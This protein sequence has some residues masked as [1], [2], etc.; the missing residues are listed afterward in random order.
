MA[1]F[2]DLYIDEV[3][4][5]TNGG[6]AYTGMTNMLAGTLGLNDLISK[7]S[8]YKFVIQI[9]NGRETAI[10]FATTNAR[11]NVCTNYLD[12]GDEVAYNID[13]NYDLNTGSLAKHD[14]VYVGWD[15]G[16]S[17]ITVHHEESSL[18]MP[19]QKHLGNLIA[20]ARVRLQLDDGSGTLKY[21]DMAG[22]NKKDDGGEFFTGSVVDDVLSETNNQDGSLR[23]KRD[24]QINIPLKTYNDAD[25]RATTGNH[26]TASAAGDPHIKTIH[27]ECYE[28]D[29]LGAFR[30]FEYSKN[31][32]YMII[33]GQSETGPG[34]WNKK[35]YIRKL[36]IQNNISNILLD[37]GFR[38]SPVK[39]LENNGI[40]YKEKTL[41]FNKDAKRYYFNNT[42]FTLDLDEPETEN[43]PGLIRNQLDITLN[44]NNN[45]DNDELAFI[46]LQNVNEFNLQPCRLEI[47]VSKKFINTAKG[48]LIDRKYAPIS[49]LDK[50][51]DITPLE[52]PTLE[53]LKNIPKL[54]IEPKL[55]NIEWK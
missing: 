26:L 42:L 44:I 25:W 1:T 28:F 21:I 37:L 17:G 6:S 20:A 53:D 35:Q 3:Y 48:C 33:N 40:T 10:N 31:G 45:V 46:S 8:G 38:G 18:L 4:I 51:T 50:I 12:D 5:D 47:N 13:K 16:I 32:N 19:N 29:Y 34:R 30:M 14:S 2:T 39:V 43:L 55:R 11:V 49:K 52:E 41:S 23:R 27:G 54:E 22:N 24:V 7:T 36:F 9:T 15:L